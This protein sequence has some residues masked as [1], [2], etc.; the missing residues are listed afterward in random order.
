MTRAA[1]NIVFYY[2]IAVSFWLAYD[3]FQ[4]TKVC[5]YLISEN[6]LLQARTVLDNLLLVNE[7]P[8]STEV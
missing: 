6:I 1:E 5:S 4:N 7:K 3:T 2:L 8:K